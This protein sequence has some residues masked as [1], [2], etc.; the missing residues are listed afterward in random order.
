MVQCIFWKDFRGGKC[1]FS[2]I[3]PVSF[4]IFIVI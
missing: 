2:E 4:D 1:L 3:I